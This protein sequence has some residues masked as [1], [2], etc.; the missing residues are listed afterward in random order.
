MPTGSRLVSALFY[1]FLT[2]VAAHM[3]HAAFEADVGYDLNFGKFKEVAAFIGVITGWV[4]QGNR[5]GE[6]KNFAIQGGV[7]TVVLIIFW[8]LVFWS[9]REMVVES[10]KLKYRGP[11][12]AL[13]DSFNIALDNVMTFANLQ[14]CITVFVGGI[15][16]GMLAERAAQRYD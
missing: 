12:A 11:T 2:Y 7:L 3:V 4:V 5:V 9:L 8:N 10:M 14:F 6:G 13:V 16:G 15:L 1:G